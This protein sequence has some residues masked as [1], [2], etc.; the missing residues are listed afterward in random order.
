MNLGQGLSSTAGGGGE[1][2]SGSVG[3][4]ATVSVVFGVQAVM[5]N[6]LSDA[7]NNKRNIFGMT[8]LLEKIIVVYLVDD[9]RGIFGVK[10]R[11]RNH[12]W[13]L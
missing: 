2:G 3:V 12:V 13:C 8:M 1:G 9:A 4:V 11:L 7:Q 5:N 6:T 10:G